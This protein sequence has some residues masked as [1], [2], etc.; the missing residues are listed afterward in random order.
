MQCEGSCE[1]H[2]GEVVSVLCYAPGDREP[3][4]FNYCEEAIAEDERRGFT[5]IR[6]NP[7]VL[8]LAGLAA[9]REQPV[10][11]MSVLENK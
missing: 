6:A 10:V 11:G 1:E 7:K 5:V 2:K 9:S 4:K 8:P 3:W